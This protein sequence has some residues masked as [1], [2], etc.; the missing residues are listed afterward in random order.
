M[1]DMYT[2]A[3]GFLFRK[4]AKDVG[5]APFATLELTAIDGLSAEELSDMEYYLKEFV[6]GEIFK[7]K[8]REDI[9]LGPVREFTHEVT[10]DAVGNPDRQQY[11]RIGPKKTVKVCSIE[12]AVEAVKAYQSHYDMGCGNCSKDHGVVWEL[13]AGKKRRKVGEVNYGGRYWTLAEKAAWEAETKAKYSK[14]A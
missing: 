1:I 6:A 8:G 3:S 14:S 5:S 12:E 4:G 13:P 7:R 9:V 2:T 10:L 11:A